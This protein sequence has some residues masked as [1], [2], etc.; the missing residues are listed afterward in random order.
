MRLSPKTANCTALSL[1]ESG[2]VREKESLNRCVAL[3][4]DPLWKIDVKASDRVFLPR[5]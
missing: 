2:S 4:V 1:H 5:M 3:P